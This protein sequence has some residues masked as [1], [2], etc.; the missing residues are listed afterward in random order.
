[1][2]LLI[3]LLV[4]FC[5]RKAFSLKFVIFLKVG[6]SLSNIVGTSIRRFLCNMNLYI[7]RDSDVDEDSLESM[8]VYIE[9]YKVFRPI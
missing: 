9:P 8:Y 3:F 7:A 1:M 5:I 4:A 6:K 2:I